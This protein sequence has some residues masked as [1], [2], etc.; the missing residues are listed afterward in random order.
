MKW[1]A[2]LLLLIFC[3]AGC[4]EPEFNRTPTHLE[5]DALSTP[6]R[7]TYQFQNATDAY[8]SRDFNWVIFQGRANPQSS[9][10]VYIAQ[11]HRRFEPLAIDTPIR[12]SHPGTRSMCG[13]FSPDANSLIFATAPMQPGPAPI[14]ASGVNEQKYP[15][16]M[17]IMRGDS[18]PAAA[19]GLNPGDALNLSLHNLTHNIAYD[20]EC[21]YSPD[22]KWIVFT[23]FRTGDGDVYVMHPD[24]SHVVQITKSPGLDGDA[25]FSPDGRRLVYRSD[26]QQNG[27]FQ[28]F[29]GTLTFDSSGQITGIAG[30]RR[31]TH[32]ATVHWQPFWHPDGRHIVYATTR[33]PSQQG[34]V[35]NELYLMRDDGSHKT[36][37]TFSPAFDGLPCFS[38]DGTYLMWTSTRVGEHSPQIFI[39]RFQM[40]AG[41]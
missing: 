24:G 33:N 14:I 20:G 23:S 22:G 38:G 32:E 21:S 29:V 16:A 17:E 31:L 13:A 39:S 12:V 4:A 8:F 28:I 11:L 7:L 37:L 19:A 5:S 27:Q 26:R 10:D 15:P 25:F 6:T 1:I 34:G 36:R 35:N 40:P 30:E 41:S 3:L 9:V 18:W 2:P